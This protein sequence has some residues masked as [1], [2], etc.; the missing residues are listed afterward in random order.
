MTTTYENQSKPGE[1]TEG[2]LYN[3]IGF[4]YNQANDP[5]GGDIVFYNGVGRDISFTNG[6]KS[7]LPSQSNTAK[8]SAPSYA[9][10]PKS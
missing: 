8:S 9:N 2:W 10:F 7:A 3:E 1:I 6:S 4:A 5:I